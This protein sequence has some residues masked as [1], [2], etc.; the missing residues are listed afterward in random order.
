[1]DPKTMAAVLLI[2]NSTRWDDY[3]LCA[4]GNGP[5]SCVEY[6]G[7]ESPY[8]REVGGKYLIETPGQSWVTDCGDRCCASE[9]IVYC[10]TGEGFSIQIN[11]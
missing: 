10:N 4:N 8:L 5:E 7:T 3:K 1:M 2:L 9:S 11:Q 6:E